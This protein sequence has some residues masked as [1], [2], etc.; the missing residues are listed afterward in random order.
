MTRPLLSLARIRA[1]VAAVAAAGL[2][3]IIL[4]SCTVSLFPYLSES[5]SQLATT[6]VT[7]WEGQSA[8]RLQGSFQVQGLDLTTDAIISTYAMSGTASGTANASAYEFLEV[9][10]KTYLKGQAFWQT[11]YSGSSDDQLVAKGFQENWTVAGGANQVAGA[12]SGLSSLDNLITVLSNEAQHVK[13]GAQRTYQGRPVTELTDGS[14]H[15]W[16]TTQGSDGR[17]VEV[18]AASSGS[19][20]QVA[21]TVA[22]APMPRGLAG[23]LAQPVVDP[24]QPSTMPALYEVLGQQQTGACDQSGC[25]VDVTVENKAGAPAGP[26]VVTV[27]AYRD[28]GHTQTITSCTAT[29][30]ASIATNQ[31]GT[32]SCTLAGAPWSAF[33]S[34]SPNGASFYYQGQVTSNPPYR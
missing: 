9:G 17:V 26:G 6:A 12:L 13:K 34:A 16:W 18:V 1:R 11:Y 15:A 23:R 33:V 2:A 7:N 29:V 20:S 22:P 3:A 31:S 28:A 5:A 24:N 8:H 4:S 10:G 14:G 32:A 19:L 25:G 21:L 30:P 27:T